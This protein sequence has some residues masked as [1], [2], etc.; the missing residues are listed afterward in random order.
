MKINNIANNGQ[1]FKGLH[2]D[3][4]YDIHFKE[5]Y[6]NQDV[7][8]TQKKR[9]N[10]EVILVGERFSKVGK[11]QKENVAL[12]LNS[13]FSRYLFQRNVAVNSDY[14]NSNE[15]IFPITKKLLSEI[16][17]KS[18]YTSSGDFTFFT[19]GKSLDQFFKL[20]GKQG[21]PNNNAAEFKKI[22]AA[23]NGILRLLQKKETFTKD[24][25]EI[26]ISK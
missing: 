25:L 4:L 18:E 13:D 20:F 11:Y 19:K 7:F 1:S 17:M 26:K 21:D 5:V 2:I 24:N 22:Y 8:V 6:F 14:L 10:I 15:V 9:T 3:K 23:C 16:N 12:F